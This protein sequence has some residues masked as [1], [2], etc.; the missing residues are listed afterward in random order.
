MNSDQDDN[1]LAGQ[2][3]RTNFHSNTVTATETHVDLEIS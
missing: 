3:P 2:A 1:P